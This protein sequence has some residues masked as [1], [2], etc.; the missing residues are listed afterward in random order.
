MRIPEYFIEEIMP[1]ILKHEGGYVNHPSDPG[2]E[3]NF[4][5]TKRSYPRENIRALTKTRA[6]E[7]YFK[8]WWTKNKYDTIEARVVG[9]KV[10]DMAINMGPRRAH[11]ILQRAVNNVSNTNLIV[12]GAI[13][14]NTIRK[15][16]AVFNP[17]NLL[18]ELRFLQANYYKSLVRRRPRLKVFINGWLRRAKS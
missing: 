2:G 11:K 4:G 6:I 15:T 14:P 1:T 12:D 5:I 3:T 18:E 16:N 17:C 10:M 13:G 9:L 7:I 8:D